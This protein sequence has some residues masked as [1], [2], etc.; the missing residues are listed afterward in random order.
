MKRCQNGTRRFPAKTGDCISKQNLSK[1]RCPNGTRRS[2]SGDCVQTKKS[3]SN[4]KLTSKEIKGVIKT[5]L[6]DNVGDLDDEYDFF[7]LADQKKII[8]VARKKNMTKKEIY[9]NLEQFSKRYGELF[10]D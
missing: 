3:Y 7:T 10:D 9:D 1:K 6:D 5:W 8:R 4:K 2:K